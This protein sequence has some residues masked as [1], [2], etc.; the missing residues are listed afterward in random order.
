MIIKNLEAV[1]IESVYECF[2]DAFSDYV[3]FRNVPFQDFLN[4]MHLR[5]MDKKFSFGVFV[6]N[7]LAGVLLNAYQINDEINLAY[8]VSI[9]VRPKYRQRGIAQ[10]LIEHSIDVFKEMGIKNYK[11]EVITINEKAYNLYTKLGFER[12]RNFP[13][14]KI[15]QINK[16]YQVYKIEEVDKIDY[17]EIK[18]LMDVTPSWQNALASLNRNPK[19]FT[20]LVVKEND[21]IIGYLIG[22]VN[23]KQLMQIAVHPKYR[24]KGIGSALL[25]ELFML[26]QSQQLGILNVDESSKSLIEFFKHFKSEE[27]LKQYELVKAL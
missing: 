10:N 16:D 4:M 14:L 21:R 15:N 18:E 19:L 5:A 23:K 8:V 25:N 24:R 11:L 1:S 20:Y 27:I 22:E 7:E 9:G 26:T 13:C 6:D 17:N 2:S 12:N 3:G